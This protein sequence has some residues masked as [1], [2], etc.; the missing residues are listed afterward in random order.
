MH[1]PLE[2]CGRHLG[3]PNSRRTHAKTEKVESLAMGGPGR[4]AIPGHVNR[5]RQ[6]QKPKKTKLAGY[7][8]RSP[9]LISAQRTTKAEIH[10]IS[11]EAS[12]SFHFLPLLWTS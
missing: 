8:H 4:D 7:M 12:K 6:F 2:W 1:P 11:H 10:A 5:F 9:P 3:D